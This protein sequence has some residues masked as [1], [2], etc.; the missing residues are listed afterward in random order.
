M[1]RE[2][3]PDYIS[4]PDK[5]RGPSDVKDIAP[6]ILESE[7]IEVFAVVILSASHQLIAW[8]EVSRGILDMT[9]V[10]PREVFKAAI[11][12]NAAAIIMVHNH[13]SGNPTPSAQDREISNRMKEVGK[14]IGIPVLD[15]IVIGSGCYRSAMEID[16]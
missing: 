12:H 1:V 8:H 6:A 15:H 13:P 11:L 16:E 5:C 4:L 14:I 9:L 7:P 10:H 3:W 2:P